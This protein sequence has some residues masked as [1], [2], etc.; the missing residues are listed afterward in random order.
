MTLPQLQFDVPE[1]AENIRFSFD[2]FNLLF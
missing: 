1:V 2:L